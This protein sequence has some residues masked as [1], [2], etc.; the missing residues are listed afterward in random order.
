VLAP[1]EVVVLKPWHA[2]LL[3]P[4]YAM[5]LDGAI[6]SLQPH[7]RFALALVAVGN[8]GTT[9]TRIPETLFTLQD[10]QNNR[11]TALPAAS[12][13]YLNTYGRGQRGDLS[14]EEDIPP[15]GSNLSIPLI[16]DIPADARDLTLHVGDQ[17]LGW[18]I[19]AA[20]VPPA[21][22]AP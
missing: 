8:D 13:A 9:P 18:P 1:G 16:F 5:L 11:Y 2:S 4:D 20:G 17:P 15:G 21:A 22:P 3:R 6:G 7:G 12:T 19:G 14:L 10:R